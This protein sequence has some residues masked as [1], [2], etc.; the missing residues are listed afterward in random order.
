[1][2]TLK[3]YLSPF[4]TTSKT[5]F[6]SRHRQTMYNEVITTHEKVFLRSFRGGYTQKRGKS[7]PCKCNYVLC[8]VVFTF[9]VFVIAC[10]IT[11]PLVHGTWSVRGREVR[12]L[13]VCCFVPKGFSSTHPPFF[14]RFLLIRSVCFSFEVLAPTAIAIVCTYPPLAFITHWF[15]SCF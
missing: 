2:D 7:G 6:G 1:M 3:D 8:V 4:P 5:P 10:V 12:C 11:V 9:V 13:F 14:L 15:L